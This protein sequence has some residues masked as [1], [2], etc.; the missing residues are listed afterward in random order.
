MAIDERAHAVAAGDKTLLFQHS[1]RI[2]QL[3]AADTK[4]LGQFGFGRK[5][6]SIGIRAGTHSFQQD[7]TDRF[8]RCGLRGHIPHLPFQQ[9]K[10]IP[11]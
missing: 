7:G 8:L 3:G 2:P 11:L 1:Q 10:V 9:K 6:R 5:V 4:S